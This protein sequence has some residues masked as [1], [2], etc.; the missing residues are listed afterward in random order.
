MAARLRSMVD[1]VTGSL[2]DTRLRRPNDGIGEKYPSEA[3]VN[4]VH[5]PVEH[6]NP[7][8]AL[9]ISAVADLQQNFWVTHTPVISEVTAKDGGSNVFDIP[10]MSRLAYNASAIHIN[11]QI[12]A[13]KQSGNTLS[14]KRTHGQM[15]VSEVWLDPYKFISHFKFIGTLLNVPTRLGNEYTTASGYYGTVDR[16][17]AFAHYGALRMLN[18]F[19]RNAVVQQ[20]HSCWMIV[21]KIAFK[22]IKPLGRTKDTSERAES[23]DRAELRPEH[24]GLVFVFV[25]TNQDPPRQATRDEII[26]CR[27]EKKD[28][29][30]E[31]SSYLDFEKKKMKKGG[32]EVDT[33]VPVIKKAP[34]IFL[35]RALEDV[36]NENLVNQEI[37][38]YREV[39][40]IISTLEDIKNAGAPVYLSRPAVEQNFF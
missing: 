1:Q 19:N 7:T 27:K 17:L 12:E 40:F 25:V 9:M 37:Q 23:V 3:F 34:V 14:R 4:A 16:P 32:K 39:E 35:G 38:N 26:E 28:P 8:G 15:D 13:K 30:Y 18:V 24:R 6:T 33:F 10:H 22:S 2:T 21:K 11:E 20:G 36:V 31:C 29:P 5:E